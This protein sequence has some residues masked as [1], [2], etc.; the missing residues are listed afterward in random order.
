MERLIEAV[1]LAEQEPWVHTLV[2]LVVLLLAAW[3]A[4]FIARR[5]VLRRLAAFARRSSNQ[6]D[7]LIMQRG[8]LRYVA[9]IA[10]AAVI[11]FGVLW[12]PGLPEGLVLLTRNLALAFT[13]LMMVL[14]ASAMLS[15]AN[16]IYERNERARARPIRGY[17]QLAKIFLFIVGAILIVSV[18]IERS[19][20]LLLSGLGAMTAVLLLV[21]KDTILSFVA[22]LQIASYDMVRVGDWIEMP[23]LAADGDVIEI[24]L[25]TVK[26]QN[27]D[28]TITA[29]PT[30][31]LAT[32]SFRNWRGMTDS[33]GR[34]IKRALLIDTGSIH[35]LRAEELTHLQRFELLRDYLASKR[36]ELAEWN[37]RHSGETNQRRLTNIGT[38]RAYVAAYLR[39]NAAI[40]PAMIQMVRQ[41]QP[42]PQGLP[43]EI[44]CFTAD[45]RWIQ[46]EAAIADLFDHLLAIAAEFG[47]RVYQQP[48][49]HDLR[50]LPRAQAV[51]AIS[52]EAASAG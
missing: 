3:L 15:A 52:P 5:V 47:L 41:L 7:D 21:F 43:L 31:R 26:V 42:G 38:F 45:T 28:R 25:H 30:W 23:A 32:E 8:A 13:I 4:D 29:I 6:W 18:L 16:D 46:H 49:S 39:A 34:R 9:H 44:Y 27:W 10:P 33:G 50:G 12:L 17:V 36:Q 48:S 14:A 37:A 2:A 40:H 35:F 22:A 51:A 24:G 20:L 19:P 1:G 11:Q